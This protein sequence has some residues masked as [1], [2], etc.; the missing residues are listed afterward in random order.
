M[1]LTVLGSGVIISGA[2]R[3]CAGYVLEVGKEKF[4]FDFGTGAFKALQKNG[5]DFLSVNNFFFTHFD[6]PDHV[7]DFVA[8]VAARFVVHKF[9]AGRSNSLNVVA[10]VGFKKFFSKFIEIYPFLKKLPFKLNIK[11]VSNSGFKFRGLAVLACKVRHTKTSVGYRV[12][13]GQKT[14]S[15]GGDTGYCREIVELCQKSDLA[16]LEC[17]LAETDAPLLHLNASTC[18]LIAR[19]ARAKKL[20]LSHI[21]PFLEKSDLAKIAQAGFGGKVLAAKD[22]MVL[23]I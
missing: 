11:E 15:Y 16:V 4:V 6:H 17:S 23:K 22:G 20:V 21:Y 12:S 10:P 5:F 7:N 9:N 14:F 19:E 1:K 18:A 8:L 13:L 2:G 3:N